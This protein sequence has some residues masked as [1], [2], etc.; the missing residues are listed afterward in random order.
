M[1]ACILQLVRT[2]LAI[3]LISLLE[4]SLAGADDQIGERY[5]DLVQNGGSRATLVLPQDAGAIWDDAAGLVQDPVTRWG[6]AGCQVARLSRDADLPAGNLILVGTSETCRTLHGWCQDPNNDLSR[7]AFA[8]AQGFVVECVQE[9]GRKILVIVGN[10]PRGAFNGVVFCRDF[11]L[12]ADAG[13]T[14]RATVFVRRASAWRSPQ[15]GTRGTYLLSLYGV[16]M[17]YSAQD[18]MRVMDRFAQDG[19]NRVCFWLSGHCP[20][21]K[22]PHLFNVDAT[23]G[24]QLTVEG[25]RELI[26][27]CHERDIEFYIGGGVFAWTAAHY[28]MQDHPEICAVKASGLCPSQEL[29]RVGNREHF[30]EMYDTWPEADGFMFEIRDEHGECQCER[31]QEKLDEF[32][33]KGYGRAE[34]TWLQEFALDAWQRNPKLKFCWLIGYD[35]HRQDVA[36]YEQIRRMKDP[37]FEWLDTRVGLDLAAP[38]RLP[39]AGDQALPFSSFSRQISHWDQFYKRSAEE[40]LTAARRTAEE[41]LAGYVPAFEPGFGSGSYYGDQIPLPMDI[42]PYCLTGLVYREATWDPNLTL[43]QAE[44]RIQRRYSSDIGAREVARALLSDQQLSFAHWQE[45]TQYARPR[46]W[47]D[48]SLLDRLTVA[49]ELGRVRAVQDETAR[50]AAAVQLLATFRGLQ[51]VGEALSRMAARNDALLAKSEATPKDRDGFEL[52]TRFLADTRELFAAAVPDAAELASAIAA[53]EEFAPPS[54]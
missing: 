13:E 48:G 6:G 38:W 53:L 41:G 29:A 31:C 45:L 40:L 23:K 33:S 1:R 52:L 44:G 46:L 2:S 12:D 15:I 26:R 25:V 8:D 17:K 30:L 37:R 11:L 47:Y 4:A 18:W 36:Y 21:Q 22:Y 27:Y 43:D 32:G 20:S 51:S 24:T 54:R 42:L 3:C 19:M 10:T 7:V 9:G 14:G 39:A 35:E 34:I 5:F 50:R 28:L 49:G 16:A